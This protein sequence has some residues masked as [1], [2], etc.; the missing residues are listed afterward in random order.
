[1]VVFAGTL[2]FLALILYV[3]FLRNLF[4]F[5]TLYADD[6]AICFTGGVLSILWFE[7]VKVFWRE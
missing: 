2:F 3:P 7:G 4:L 5:S 6:L 1:V